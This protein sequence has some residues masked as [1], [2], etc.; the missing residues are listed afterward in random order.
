MTPPK[1]AK[2]W[3]VVGYGPDGEYTDRVCL[4]SRLNAMQET[5]GSEYRPSD[6]ICLFNKAGYK[7][8]PC[9]ITVSEDE[10]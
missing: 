3:V 8:V 5:M 7:L 4:G 9:T 10:R 1:A 2:G 6:A